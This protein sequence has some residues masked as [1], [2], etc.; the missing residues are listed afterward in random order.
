MVGDYNSSNNSPELLKKANWRYWTGRM[1]W[2]NAKTFEKTNPHEYLVRRD[3]DPLDNR[4]FIEFV[5]FVKLHGTSVLFNGKK[6]FF[7]VIGDFNYFVRDVPFDSIRVVCR[8]TFLK[9]EKDYGR[10]K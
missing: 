10:R 8:K 9:G 1:V 6:H 7:Y 5:K 4:L 3:L 2:V